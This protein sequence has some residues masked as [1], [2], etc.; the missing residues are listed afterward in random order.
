[1]LLQINISNFALIEKLTVSFKAG[2]NVFSGETGAGKS[3]LIDAISFVLGGK[4]NKNLIRTGADSTYV[5]AVF[6]ID[7]KNTVK[8]LEKLGIK[9]EDMVIISREV[10]KY[11]KSITKVNGRAVLIS[12]LKLI[13]KTLIDIHGQNENQN[14]LDPLTHI[15]YVD[16]YG[17]QK[18][19]EIFN[20]YENL[21]KYFAEINKKIIS[22]E[23]GDN[24]KEIDYLKFQI[25]EIE[26]SNIKPDEDSELEEK[27]KVMSN[28]EKISNVLSD[29][30]SLLHGESSISVYDSIGKI[31]NKMETIEDDFPK[32]SG[33]LKSLRE[34]YYNVEQNIEEIRDIREK[35][36][37]DEN[38][39]NS[40]NER[41]YEINLLKRKYGSTIE[42]ILNYKKNI[43]KRYNELMNSEEIIDELREKMESI[44]KKLEEKSMEL[45]NI[46]CSVSNELE[47]KVK[48]ELNEIGLEKSVFKI[49]ITQKD[50]FGADGR[51]SIQF[52]IST[53]PGEPLMPLEKVVSGGELS[54]IML[55]LKTVF[56]DK[57]MVPSIIFDEIDT[58]ISG[59]VAQR[60]AEKM[61]KISKKRQVFCVTHLPQIASMSDIHF[62][63]SKKT[64]ENKT[65]T[66]IKE[67]TTEEK[68]D[69][70]ARMTGGFEVTKITME[71]ARELVKMAEKKKEE[72]RNI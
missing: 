33:I 10:L 52:L 44:K 34:T 67:L 65:Y 2:L 53:N 12:Q 56:A 8:I 57:D 5:E 6:S 25:N 37:Y 30:Y 11:G 28:A 15:K 42:E 54:R 7:N 24:E 20:S 18:F 68:I 48:N 29:A 4:S 49:Q 60:V 47:K 62:R 43:E 32:I 1:M 40:V 17:G 38:E 26:N 16:V 58:G 45:H 59:R 27:Y 35:V 61:V 69:E 46:R 51:D 71:N 22:F 14:L 55:A 9:T 72:I 23:N 39:L 66:F 19:L 13:S 41:I 70:I 64:I 36:Y 3:I 31:I 50:E 21:Y 63:V